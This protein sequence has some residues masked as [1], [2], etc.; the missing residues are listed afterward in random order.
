MRAKD[1]A[2]AEGIS[3]STA[4]RLMHS[5]NVG[6]IHGRNQRDRWIDRRL[7][8]SWLATL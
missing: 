7:Y 2:Q 6:P 8:L 3:I 5:G 1:L 4:R